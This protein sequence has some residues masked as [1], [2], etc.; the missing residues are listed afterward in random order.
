MAKWSRW[1]EEI[2]LEKSLVEKVFKVL[3]KSTAVEF[4]MARRIDM[5][6]RMLTSLFNNRRSVVNG[7]CR[8]WR[9]SK[10]DK[11]RVC[12]QRPAMPYQYKRELLTHDDVNRFTNA[13]EIFNR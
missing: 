1:R 11:P 2:Y 9:Y 13:C 12:R 4:K 5:I 3:E 8:L 6:T 7:T 10:A